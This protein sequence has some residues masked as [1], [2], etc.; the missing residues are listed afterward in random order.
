MKTDTSTE[1]KIKNARIFTILLLFSNILWSLL[2]I[3][4]FLIAL[5]VQEN[6][7][8]T[9]GQIFAVVVVWSGF[10]IVFIYSSYYLYKKLA[11]LKNNS[12]VSYQDLHLFSKNM[13]IFCSIFAFL[14]INTI[15]GPIFYGIGIAIYSGLYN[16]AIKVLKENDL[17]SK[18]AYA[19]SQS[20][21]PDIMNQIVPA[22]NKFALNSYYLGVV[23]M[24]PLIGI[25][26]GITAIVF[27]KKGKIYAN[28]NPGVGGEAHCRIGVGLSIFGFILSFIFFL[29]IMTL[30]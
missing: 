22:R 27:S 21:V 7:A 30:V 18:E 2:L 25:P 9:T 19:A 10:T 1:K 3:V 6:T 14:S 15:I 5:F 29:L 8:L 28:Q 13:M 23:G 11:L 24:I 4:L 26:F 17:H 12:T 20:A 16:K